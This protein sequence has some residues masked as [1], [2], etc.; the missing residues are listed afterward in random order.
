MCK[1]F[2]RKFINKLK[3]ELN[4]TEDFDAP[5]LSDSEIIHPLTRNSRFISKELPNDWTMISWQRKMD[6]N[7]GGY[8]EKY[9]AAVQELF[10]TTKNDRFRLDDAT[11][12]I[13]FLARHTIE[14]RLKAIILLLDKTACKGSDQCISQKIMKTHSLLTLWNQFDNLYIGDKSDEQYKSAYILII[15]FNKL[16]QGSD[17]YRYP[18]HIDGKPTNILE[19]IDIRNFVQVF[20]SLDAFLYGIETMLTN[21]MDCLSNE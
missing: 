19:H 15:D 1:D 18:V 2:N 4:Q 12:P 9:S 14:L 20:K 7:F 11:Y 13:M 21:G 3:Q 6:E 16:D 8:A 5:P 10:E 17:T